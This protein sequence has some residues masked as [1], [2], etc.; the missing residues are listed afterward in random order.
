MKSGTLTGIIILVLVVICGGYLAISNIT[1]STAEATIQESSDELGIFRI[2]DIVYSE[3]GLTIRYAGC[4]K[5]DDGAKTL[6][7]IIK[8]G[9]GTGDYAYPIYSPVE[10][11]YGDGVDVLRIDSVVIK[12]TDLDID[13]Y[14]VTLEVIN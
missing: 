13:K 11:M 2:D 7:F 8:R 1:T 12:I 5:A 9:V 14:H 3:L 4:I 10:T 6:V